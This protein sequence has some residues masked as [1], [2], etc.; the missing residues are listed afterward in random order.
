MKNI[1]PSKWEN[2]NLR[3]LS[4]QWWRE[5]FKISFFLFHAY[6][7]LF[8]FPFVL[9]RSLTHSLTIFFFPT[10]KYIKTSFTFFCHF[11]TVKVSLQ[12]EP[13]RYLDS[14]TIPI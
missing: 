14:D 12:S 2:L 13:G 3:E 1:Q 7:H 8:F 6:I 9:T 11:S 10:V 4:E 5:D